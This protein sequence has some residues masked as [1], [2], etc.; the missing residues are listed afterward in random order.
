MCVCISS[1]STLHDSFGSPPSPW[2]GHPPPRSRSPPLGRANQSQPSK[3]TPRGRADQSQP[4]KDTPS[5]SVDARVPGFAT[6]KVDWT[7]KPKAK[8]ASAQ[9]EANQ[10]RLDKSA[11]SSTPGDVNKSQRSSKSRHVD[12]STPKGRQTSNLAKASVD[13]A[14]SVKKDAS[15]R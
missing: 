15:V 11:A 4:S 13:A 3:D 1:L 9:S 6:N 8:S 14:N 7:P 5:V 12:E 2:G 10:S